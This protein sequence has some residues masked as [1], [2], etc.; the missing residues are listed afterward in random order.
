[1]FELLI[2]IRWSDE[3][4]NQWEVKKGWYRWKKGGAD[5][6]ESNLLG[7]AE[8]KTGSLT[9]VWMRWEKGENWV[10]ERWERWK[11]GGENWVVRTAWLK[12]DLSLAKGLEVKAL[13]RKSESAPVH[14]NRNPIGRW[15]VKDCGMAHHNSTLSV[16]KGGKVKTWMVKGEMTRFGEQRNGYECNRQIRWKTTVIQ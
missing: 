15:R 14:K 11:L 10:V 3:T 2:C 16:D 4:Q 5:W 12:G 9:L 6:M 1:M 7:A 13:N 8:K